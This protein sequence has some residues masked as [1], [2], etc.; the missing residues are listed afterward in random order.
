MMKTSG[1]HT[2]ERV[3]T[4]WSFVKTQVAGSQP[5]RCWLSRFGAGTQEF[6]A[7]DSGVCNSA[8]PWGMPLLREHTLRV[9]NLVAVL[10][11]GSLDVDQVQM[12]GIP[13]SVCAGTGARSVAMSQDPGAVLPTAKVTRD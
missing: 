13:E 11:L 4:I 8:C 1:L 2:S 5:R 9:T 6:G 3:A 12:A 7:G 10:L